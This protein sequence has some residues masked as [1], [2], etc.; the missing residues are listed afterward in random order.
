MFQGIRG[1]R[2]CFIC[3][4][5][6]TRVRNL[7]GFAHGR[8]DKAEG[9]AAD[10]HITKSLGNFRHVTGNA[11]AAGTGRRVMRM[12]FNGGSVRPVRRI[13]AVAVEAQAAGWFAQI[14][15]EFRAVDIVAGEAR[16]AVSIHLAGDKIIS[17]H[18]VLMGG[19]IGEMS[20]SRLAQLVFL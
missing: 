7:Q 5:D 9:M 12:R 10:I 15:G 11:L 19:A 2:R 8:S 16:H 3:M 14:G 6:V 13:G 20:E 1:P 18:P 17:L 4:T